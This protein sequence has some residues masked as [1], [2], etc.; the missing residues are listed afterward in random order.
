MISEEEA[1]KIASHWHE[2]QWSGLYAFAS[3]GTIQDR[4]TTEIEACIVYEQDQGLATADFFGDELNSLL[5][6]VR[7]QNASEV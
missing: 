3:S 6:Y 5:E 4:L 7:G 1:R 2:G